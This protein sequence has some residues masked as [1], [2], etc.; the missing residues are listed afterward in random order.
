MKELKIDPELRD[1]LPPLADDEYKQ[2]EKNIVDNGFDRNFPI[3]EWHGFIVDGHN[4]YSICRKHNIDYT[5]GTLAYETKEE[6]MRWML[7][8]QLG[9]R[10][11]TPIQRISVAEKHRVL[12]EKQAKEK[13][14]T[15][16]G[17]VH[18]QLRPEMV[19]AEKSED[20]NENKTVTKLAAIAG[21]KRET[22]RM[23]SKILNSNN[24]DLKQRVLSG[25]TSITAGYK[26]LQNKNKPKVND[27]AEKPVEKENNTTKP[28]TKPQVENGVILL[29]E[30]SKENKIMNDIARQMKSGTID[31][32]QLSNEK[33]IVSVA[34]LVDE[35]MCSI[36]NYIFRNIDFEKFSRKNFDE[37]E[38]ILLAAKDTID[39]K[40]KIM[41]E[42][43]S[44]NE[45]PKQQIAEL[46]QKLESLDKNIESLQTERSNTVKKRGDLFKALDVKCPVKYKWI[47]EGQD[48]FPAWWKCQIYIDYDGL[49]EVLGE[50]HVS[51]SE[52]PNTY[53]KTA[54]NGSREEIS[55]KYHDDFRMIWKQA[56]DEN[57][58]LEMKANDKRTKTA[59]QLDY[60]MNRMK[61][62][63]PV[64][65]DK[66][67]CRKFYRTL[68]NEYHPDN[69][70]T[71][72]AEMMQYVNELKAAWGI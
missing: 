11:L 27:V 6:V 72:D 44:S 62:Y 30:D 2:L 22:Y 54:V 42:K 34:A 8:I 23:G 9:R 45:T 57:V 47:K 15:S 36:F 71:G 53:M 3:M 12:F 66:N 16:T 26:E 56:H 61:K 69:D 59:Q 52:L 55:Q 43:I 65:L 63:I 40:I 51:H 32:T 31:T 19:Q 4:R 10:N 20:P 28:E 33:E 21:V 7:D 17:G 13:Q 25:K 48:L 60:E 14:A 50:Y 39:K 37:I 64:G 46:D 49:T 5:I 58:R 18:P 1:L 67:V 35:S 68:A 70:K 38:N 24:D 41:E 29:P